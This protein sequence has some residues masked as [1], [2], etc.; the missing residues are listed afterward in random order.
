MAKATQGAA[1][2]AAQEEAPVRSRR[3]EMLDLETHI[4]EDLT[5]EIDALA[6]AV[7]DLL[8]GRRDLTDAQITEDMVQQLREMIFFA[9]MNGARGMLDMAIDERR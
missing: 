1:A 7:F 2:H 9:A 3:F 4:Q 5:G 6:A 8:K